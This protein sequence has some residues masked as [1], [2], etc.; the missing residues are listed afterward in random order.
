MELGHVDSAEGLDLSLPADDPI[1][2]SVLSTD[3][4]PTHVRVGLPIWNK[5]EWVGG[6]YPPGTPPGNYLQPYGRIYDTVEVNSTFYHPP[7]P[8]AIAGWAESVP[9]DF[10]F[11][12]KVWRQISHVPDATTADV[13]RFVECVSAFGDRLGPCFLQLPPHADL[14]WK[15]PLARL[16]DLLA[17]EV[18]LALELRHP[19][20][21]SD[22]TTRRRLFAHLAERRIGLVITDTAGRRDLVHMGVSA[23][24]TLIRFKGQGFGPLDVARADDWVTR[25]ASWSARGLKRAYFIAHERTD[26]E[27]EGAPIARRIG[28]GLRARGIPVARAMTLPVDPQLG[29]L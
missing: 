2:T 27:R 15:R 13:A 22:T 17:P 26:H 9:D 25:L 19:A 23:E 6:I 4:F 10:S 16:L 24:F 20:W 12:P 28:E 21:F 7:A 14:T 3:P 18:E 11:L 29:L 8:D 1:T 5:K